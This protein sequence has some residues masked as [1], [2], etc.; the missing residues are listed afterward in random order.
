M[1]HHGDRQGEGAA[2]QTVM[3]PSF[4]REQG[5]VAIALLRRVGSSSRRVE[6]ALWTRETSRELL[7]SLSMILIFGERGLN[8]DNVDIN[9]PRAP[10]PQSAYFA[11]YYGSVW[12]SSPRVTVFAAPFL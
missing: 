12:D 6:R 8:V 7:K 2:E 1:E 5:N 11:C 4:K 10:A 9:T 3:T